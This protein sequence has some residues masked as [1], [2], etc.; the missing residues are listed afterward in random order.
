VLFRSDYGYVDG[1]QADGQL[2]AHRVSIYDLLRGPH[3]GVRTGHGEMF[4][5]GPRQDLELEGSQDVRGVQG[6]KL[7]VPDNI[8]D[9]NARG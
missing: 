3:E 6:G 9:H 2:G 5:M 1:E 4:P 8:G 7:S